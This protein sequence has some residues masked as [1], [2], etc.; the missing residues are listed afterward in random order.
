[1]NPN[2]KPE[3]RYIMY[4]RK[5]SEYEDSQIQSIE[6]Q[7]EDLANLISR[8]KLVIFHDPLTE[9]KSAF[10]PG[11]EEFSKLVKWTVDGRVNA[12]L[13]W[14]AN[15]LS[16][17]PVDTGT[18]IYLMDQGKLHHIRTRERV[19]YNTPSDKFHLQL[20]LSVSKK[21]SDDKS[22]LIKS[23]I[24]RRH[25]RG[26]PNGLPPLGYKLLGSG[27]S[28]HSFWVVDEPRFVLIKKIFGKFLSG[29]DSLR[30][31]REYAAK[32]GLRTP[33]RRSTGGLHP[34]KSTMRR[35]ILGN[36][37]YA[38]YFMGS[39]GQRYQLDQT[40]PRVITE[41]QHERIEE[42]LGSHMNTK[43]RR[44]RTRPVAYRDVITCPEG[45]KLGVDVKF[46]VIC[47]CRTTFAYLGR[48][49]CP[50]CGCRIDRLEAPK[51]L[52]YTYYFST[53]D[54]RRSDRVARVVE[55][56]KIDA[57][58]LENLAKPLRISPQLRDWAMAYLKELEDQ[59]L[60]RRDAEADHFGEFKE[61]FSSKRRRLRE[62]YVS[63]QITE[64]EFKGD[65]AEMERI[66]TERQEQLAERES[67]VTDLEKILNLAVELEN[68]IRFGD[69]KA[70]NQAFRNSC[71]N[72]TWDGKSLFICNTKR[73]NILI[74]MLRMARQA[75][76]AFEPEKC[77]DTSTRNGVFMSVRP[78]LWRGAHNFR[79]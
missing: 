74:E 62:L 51:Y 34:T 76:P 73:I 70:K 38:G 57:F 49:T 2:D 59:D 42:I 54:R 27:R 14:H 25:R 65:A 21:D 28:G 31:I 4:A 53:R 50:E 64:E 9:S 58:V 20:E 68:V 77:V 5:S 63:G 15:R 71:S 60:S 23:G 37:V 3:F 11:R 48:E 72:L 75:N 79:T 32:I 39:D 10:H 46:Q 35:N 66:F 22:A 24:L 61:Q 41:E 6:R 78:I 12:W 69:A 45:H 29:G 26:Y 30:T 56:K 40:L 47:D 17:N 55:E 7:T 33:P 18:I 52:V 1:M 16:R 67:S 36:S 13:C 19:Y 8:E 44:P 43:K